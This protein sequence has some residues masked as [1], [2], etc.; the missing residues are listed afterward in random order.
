MYIDKISHHEND[1]HSKL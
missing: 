1:M